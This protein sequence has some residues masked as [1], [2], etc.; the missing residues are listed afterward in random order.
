MY[1]FSLRL[2]QCNRQSDLL[3]QVCSSGH[4]SYL[5]LP[6]VE[7]IFIKITQ[8]T[9]QIPFIEKRGKKT[10]W[11]IGMSEFWRKVIYPLC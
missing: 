2:C 10:A 8:K 5:L 9:N 6:F 11:L 1:F 4:A 7:Q 3:S